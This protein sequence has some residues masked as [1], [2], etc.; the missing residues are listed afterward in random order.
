[1]D[2]FYSQTSS[3]I[4]LAKALF[5]DF[6]FDEIIDN[7]RGYT[8]GVLFLVYLF[9]AVFILLSMFLAI[10]G[11]AQAAVRDEE[12]Q[13][14]E[15][16]DFPN[17]YGFLG[18]AREVINVKLEHAPWKRA[19]TQ[20]EEEQAAAEEAE[21][22][23]EKARQ[24]ENPGLDQALSMALSKMQ[25]KLDAS[26]QSRMVA[27]EQKVVG[28]LAGL[29]TRIPTGVPVS[30]SKAKEGSETASGRPDHRSMSNSGRSK[31]ESP[32][33]LVRQGSTGRNECK[34]ADSGAARG[35][36]ERRDSR[37]GAAA[38]AGDSR[39]HSRNG[40]NGSAER[41]EARKA[42]PRKASIGAVIGISPTNSPRGGGGG[43]G[44]GRKGS[45]A[46]PPNRERD[47]YAC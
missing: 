41:G 22:A 27:L 29:E 31:S 36:R 34:L 25:K 4:A 16:G 21:R 33:R 38:P 46:P 45:G 2:D 13:M 23:A 24:E 11:E 30:G 1:M 19:K 43:G 26:M 39:S 9:V 35:T 20:S 28:K 7:S 12:N 15:R 32:M 14:K 37:S 5:G 6:P 47:K 8:N 18:E 42:G 17:Q 44:G 3:F 10:L 40:F